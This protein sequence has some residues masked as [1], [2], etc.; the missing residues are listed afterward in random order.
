MNSAS[1]LL[2]TMELEF[3]R[4]SISETAKKKMALTHDLTW[5]LHVQ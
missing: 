4:V 2:K 5:N 1:L 3:F